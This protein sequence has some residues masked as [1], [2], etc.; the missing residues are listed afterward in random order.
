MDGE[1][2]GRSTVK[3]SGDGGEAAVDDGKVVRGVVP[4]RKSP[5][6]HSATGIGI[7]WL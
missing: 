1:V 5:D 2:V 7:N 3:Y 6:A 4:F